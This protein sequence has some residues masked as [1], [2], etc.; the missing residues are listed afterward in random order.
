MESFGKFIVRKLS[1]AAS[2]LY[3]AL[4]FP[5]VRMHVERKTGSILKKGVYFRNG[6]TFAGKDYVG[7]NSQ[8]D[9]VHMGFSS[10][11]GRDAVISNVRIGNYSCASNLETYIGLHP[12]KGENIS[13]H[14]AFYSTNAQ[15]GHTYVNE[16]SF[17]EAKYTDEKNRIQ[18]E[19]GS[20][21]WL[22]YGVKITEGV[23]IGDGAV[24]GAGS[25]VLTSLEPY[26]I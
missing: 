5:F 2:I 26:G 15:F 16:N 25:L 1:E 13:V 19:I 21:V 22:G 3:R 23:T 4:F 14:P 18:I 20:D 9:N 12:V 11:I 7:E 8:L 6:T 10:M 17:T 24:V